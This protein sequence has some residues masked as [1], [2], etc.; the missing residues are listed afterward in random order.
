MLFRSDSNTL[1]DARILANS[2]PAR[3][4]ARF[5]ELPIELQSLVWEHAFDAEFTCE[6]TYEWQCSTQYFNAHSSKK[7]RMEI[8]RSGLGSLLLACRISREIAI[9][10]WRAWIREEAPTWQ[11]YVEQHPSFVLGEGVVEWLE[12]GPMREELTR[13]RRLWGPEEFEL[14]KGR[15]G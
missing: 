1:S 7:I 3:S 2:V 12:R 6:D 9:A 15:R 11:N 4:F 13:K 5:S 10:G 14:W 8:H